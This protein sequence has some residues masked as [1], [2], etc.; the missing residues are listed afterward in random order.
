MQMIS[1]KY[2]LVWGTKGYKGD[3]IAGDNNARLMAH[4]LIQVY[5]FNSLNVKILLNDKLTMENM[6]EDLLWLR[7]KTGE[8]S[9]VFLFYSGHGGMNSVGKFTHYALNQQLQDIRYQKLCMVFECCYSGN[10][11]EPLSGPNRL[12]IASTK[13]NSTGQTTPHGSIFG[14]YFLE[15][16]IKKGLADSN[17][18]GQVSMQEA[19]YYYYYK[20]PYLYGTMLDGYGQEFLP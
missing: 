20:N 12:I 2:A 14:F 5:G 4:L 8:N 3:Q 18:D 19:F 10:A 6:L 15:E 7:Q 16:A 17:R 1:N 13:V 9:S 11:C